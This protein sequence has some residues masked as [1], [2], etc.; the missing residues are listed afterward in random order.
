LQLAARAQ[1]CNSNCLA[2]HP[3]NS[4]NSDYTPGVLGFAVC[5]LAFLNLLPPSPGIWRISMANVRSIPEGYHTI[6]PALCFKNCSAAID[7]YKRAFGAKERMCMKSPD[8]KVAHCELQIGDSI[9][10]MGD[11]NEMS[12]TRSPQTLGGS[13]C[14]IFMYVENVDESFDRAV[15]AGGSPKMPPQDMFWGD[16][17]GHVLDPF[18]YIWGLATH[19]EDVKPDEMERRAKEFFA[20]MKAA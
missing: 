5:R 10:M 8:G 11:V 18:G 17:Y 6:T 16:R 7:F 20:K 1:F 19:K 14:T 15:K 13:N 12:P 4:L 3:K 9:I 2:A